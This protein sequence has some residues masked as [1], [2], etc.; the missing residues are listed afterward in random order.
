MIYVVMLIIL[1]IIQKHIYKDWANPAVLMTFLWVA[2][3]LLYSLNTLDLNDI[4][5][6]TGWV[7]VIGVICFDIGVLITKKCKI[8]FGK[9]YALSSEEHKNYYINYN[10]IIGVGI[11]SI[12][13]LLPDAINSIKLLLSGKNFSFIRSTNTISV[14]QNPLLL[15]IK[16]YICLSYVIFIYSFSAWCLIAGERK[17]RSPIIIIAICISVLQLFSGGGRASIVYLVVHI[18]IMNILLRQK[19]KISNK[20]K[21]LTILLAIAV[22]ILVYYVSISRGIDNI[23]ESM[24]LYYI[25]CIPLL[26]ARLEII[27]SDGLCSYGG[28]FFYG[29]LNLIFTLLGNI[30]FTEPVFFEKLKAMMNV[31]EILPVGNNLTMNAFVTCFYYFFLDGGF[32]TLII[33]SMLYGVISGSFYKDAVVNKTDLRKVIIYVIIS[34]TILFSMVRY[35]FIQYHYLLAFVMV[36]VFIRRKTLSKEE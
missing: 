9:N 14:I 7:I 10:Y 18:I 15:V 20:T 27:S 32:F 26:D 35:Q 3:M 8:L 21:S 36:F 33:E 25:G 19:V 4:S 34:N 6:K 2:I 13:L 30:G 23:K 28:A 1:F 31:E 16:N 17:Y 12:L 24:T 29:I 11:L 5:K 22:L